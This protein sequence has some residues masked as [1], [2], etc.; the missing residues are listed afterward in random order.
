V[1]IHQHTRRSSEYRASLLALLLVA[2]SPY[3]PAQDAS[4]PPPLVPWQ[5]TLD[6]ALA[7]SAKT[8]KPL[9][10]CVNADGE[11][12][13]ESIAARRY[14][15][16]DFVKLMDGFIPVIASAYTHTPRSRDGRGRRIPCP[17]FGVVTCEEHVA[18]EPLA[19]QRWFAD[20]R[21]APRHVGVSEDG[22]VLFDLYLLDSL[23]IIDSTLR[24]ERRS[25]KRLPDPKRMSERQLLASHDA[26]ANERLESVF[27][28]AKED[29]RIRM[30]T[31][32]LD[33]TRSAQHP[34]LVRLGLR[35]ASTLVRRAAAER[36]AANASLLPPD[37]LDGAARILH[38]SDVLV[39]RIVE[40]L[41][42]REDAVARRRGLLLGA[43]RDPS[44]VLDSETWMAKLAVGGSEDVPA[45]DKL[46][47]GQAIRLDKGVAA[48]PDDVALRSRLARTYLDLSRARVT[49]GESDVTYLWDLAHEEARHASAGPKAPAVALAVFARTDWLLGGVAADAAP[50]ASRA[51][52][53]LFGEARSR[54][55][56]ETLDVL[57]QSRAEQAFERLDAGELPEVEWI[58]DIAAGAQLIVRHPLA[59]P[60][61]RAAALDVVGAL[62]LDGL[63]TELAWLGINLLPDAPELHEHIRWHLM[64]DGDATQVAAA[65]DALLATVN[66]DQRPTVHWFAAF[67]QLQ[68]GDRLRD[69]RRPE[70]A[71]TNYRGSLEDFAAAIALDATL[72]N[73]AHYI[74]LAHSGQARI[75]LDRGD[76]LGAAMELLA[77]L[78][79]DGQA[80]DI[81]DSLGVTPRSTTVATIGRLRSEPKP[82]KKAEAL[83]ARL[84]SVLGF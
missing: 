55:A 53:G 9:L 82:K 6:D 61:Q 13:S 40:E 80:L 62:Q 56:V 50:A 3:A 25:G 59:T 10:V 63:H 35:D 77:G 26:R 52:P 29:A 74:T 60:W 54:L 67:A 14:R 37:V 31:S 21:V 79:P 12:A 48:A 70:D 42:D 22:E 5:R 78:E 81:P 47:N 71:L 32:S 20:R 1:L 69:E 27:V 51:L 83:A 46:L 45:D 49:Q 2:F 4:V 8:G 58:A 16:P 15:D 43:S 7:L 68:A 65:Y 75:L 39:R 28:V 73:T 66:L 11:V 76:A 33:S 84:D 34:G 17:R 19:Y 57:V 23:S 44:T 36:A 64:R 72:T 38:D 30:V 41:S 24:K 18:L